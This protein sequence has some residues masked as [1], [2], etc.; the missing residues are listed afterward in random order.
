MKRPHPL[1]FLGIAFLVLGIMLIAYSVRSGGS[2][3]YFVLV[4]P[5]LHGSDL[6]GILGMLLILAA[7]IVLPLSF[8]YQQAMGGDAGPVSLDYDKYGDPDIDRK[9]V[10]SSLGGVIFIGPIP[11]IFGSNRGVARWMMVVAGIIAVII[12]VVFILQIYRL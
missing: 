3:L 12:A 11:I 2:E 6:Y 9:R 4:F 1:L 10:K 5:V 8:A 7:F